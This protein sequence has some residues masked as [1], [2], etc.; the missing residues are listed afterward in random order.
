VLGEGL[1][2]Q[3]GAAVVDRD[4]A[5]DEVAER[6]I[7]VLGAPREQAGEQLLRCGNDER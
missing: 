1:D 3:L 6:L 4:G 7:E 5:G 2:R